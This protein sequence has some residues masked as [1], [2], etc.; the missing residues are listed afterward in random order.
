MKPKDLDAEM[1]A[2]IGVKAMPKKTVLKLNLTEE[3]Y[4]KISEIAKNNHK[5]ISE[6]GEILIVNSLK[7]YEQLKAQAKDFA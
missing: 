1:E 3:D 7:R 2:L 6:L 5:T 4:A